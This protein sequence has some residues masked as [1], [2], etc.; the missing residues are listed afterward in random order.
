MSLEQKSRKKKKKK[1][2]KRKKNIDLENRKN[3]F[4]M[5]HSVKQIP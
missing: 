1:K 3:A 5:P 2:K 4:Q